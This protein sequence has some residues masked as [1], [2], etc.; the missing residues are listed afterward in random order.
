M[1]AGIDSVESGVDT[2]LD[3]VLK[4]IT[5]DSNAIQNAYGNSDRIQNT[6]ANMGS[7]MLISGLTSTIMGLARE[8][9]NGVQAGS[10]EG[11][12]G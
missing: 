5:Y 12:T 1:K 10:F 6:L 11:M 7:A 2:L 3:P 4:Q 8:V 9:V